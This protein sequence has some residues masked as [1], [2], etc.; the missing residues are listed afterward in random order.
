MYSTTGDTLTG[1]KILLP[2]QLTLF[3]SSPCQKIKG[4]FIGINTVH[5]ELYCLLCPVYLDVKPVLLL[6]QITNHSCNA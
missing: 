1:Y 3:H 6:E 4:Y 2:W 5:V